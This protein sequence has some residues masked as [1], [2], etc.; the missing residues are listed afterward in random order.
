MSN[1][2]I[3]RLTSEHPTFIRL[4]KQAMEYGKLCA[5]IMLLTPITAP[6]ARKAYEA[7]YRRI[8]KFYGLTGKY[9]GHDGAKQRRGKA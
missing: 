7:G 9:V 6:G 5:D 4:H 1:A 2:P 3:I 8:A